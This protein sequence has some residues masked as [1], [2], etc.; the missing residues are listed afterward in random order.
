MIRI[1]RTP[2]PQTHFERHPPSA[3]APPPPPRDA[4]SK[5]YGDYYELRRYR[6]SRQGRPAVYPRYPFFPLFE[7]EGQTSLA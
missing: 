6:L 7:Q 3:A 1:A 4:R 2:T 5:L